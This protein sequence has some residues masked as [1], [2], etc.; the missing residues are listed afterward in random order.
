MKKVMFLLV[1]MLFAVSVNASTV[2][3]NSE[4]AFEAS[5]YSGSLEEFEDGT[6]NSGLSIVSDN[7]EFIIEDGVMKDRLVAGS[8]NITSFEF[9][10]AVNAFGGL[11]DLGVSGFGQGIEI[12]FQ[13]FLGATEVLS[14][15]IIGNGFF[16]FISDSVLFNKVVFSAGSGSGIAETY[17][18]DN[19]R[20]GL[21]TPSAVPVPAAL[22]LFA[23]A[24]LG[25]FGLRRKA[26]V[27][28]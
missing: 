19:L 9:G 16:G 21:H 22:F 25:F 11:F 18:L 4:A 14:T 13:A 26:A 2:V 27:A 23:P 12:S 15:Q 3:Y 28:A 1:G 17:T 10:S 8:G 5:H 7:A 6:L 20:Y 24:L